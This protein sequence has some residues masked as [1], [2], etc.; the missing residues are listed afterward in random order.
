MEVKVG[1]VKLVEAGV[2][3]DCVVVEVASDRNGME[4][5]RLAMA[6]QE[7]CGSCGGAE[8]R[9]RKKREQKY[10]KN[11]KKRKKV[12]LG[13]PPAARTNLKGLV[14]SQKNE[15]SRS[16]AAEHLKSDK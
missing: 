5:H 15:R 1:R 13:L 12:D 14:P 16:H 11:K 9:R 10:K 3:E 8:Q 2:A 6:G 7:R 4:R